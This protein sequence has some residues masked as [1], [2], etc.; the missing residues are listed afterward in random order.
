MEYEY[1]CYDFTYRRHMTLEQAEAFKARYEH[2]NENEWT[3]AKILY[4][5]KTN[6]YTVVCSRDY[7]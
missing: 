6:D 3:R 1:T 7:K 2:K 5:R 4:K